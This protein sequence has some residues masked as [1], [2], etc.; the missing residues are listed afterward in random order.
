MQFQGPFRKEH[1]KKYDEDGYMFEVKLFSEK[2]TMIEFVNQLRHIENVEI[3]KIE[4][5]LY[6]VL[7]IRRKHKDQVEL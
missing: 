5:S 7:I 3:S 1:M 4:E 6:K 2:E